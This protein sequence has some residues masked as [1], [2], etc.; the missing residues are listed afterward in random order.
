MTFAITIGAALLLIVFGLIGAFRDLPR[1]IV[2]LTGVLF[3]AVLVDFW[4]LPLAND[5][6]QRLGNP[7]IA[8]LQRFLSVTLFGTVLLI[9]GFGSGLLLPTIRGSTLPTRLAGVV[10]GLFSG[11][12]TAG[13]L[14]SYASIK[15]PP[16]LTQIQASV[17]GRP[18]LEQLP[19]LLAAGAGLISLAVLAIGLLR[20]FGG[21]PNPT[22]TPPAKTTPPLPTA[23][24]IDKAIDEKIK[25]QIR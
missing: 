17:I 13:F 23:R 14:L 21:Q 7:D 10:I 5:L 18:L 2:V 3:G 11:A 16:F 24:A 25:Q 4:A 12:L 19:L 8:L 20:L 15:N 9:V 22:I 6:S 1:G